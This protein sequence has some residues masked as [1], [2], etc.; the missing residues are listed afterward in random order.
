MNGNHAPVAT[1]L[2]FAVLDGDNPRDWLLYGKTFSELMAETRSAAEPYAV[3]RELLQQY[4]VEFE[5]I[6]VSP[7]DLLE[8]DRLDKVVGIII[9]ALPK[10]GLENDLRRKLEI[11]RG[12]IRQV[13]RR[14]QAD[15]GAMFK[16]FGYQFWFVTS[17]AR[18]IADFV[19]S[20]R[21]L[22]GDMLR[23]TTGYDIAYILEKDYLKHH[24]SAY[25]SRI[26]FELG[27]GR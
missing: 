8:E 26:Y 10:D 3:T 12:H 16:R 4:R 9:D 23:G 18:T 1:P 17:D 14:C 25:L 2:F 19:Q 7:Q 24:I 6:M 20:V 27:S 22:A 21:D 15:N 5:P 13:I 11:V